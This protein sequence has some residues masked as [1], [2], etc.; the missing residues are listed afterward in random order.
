MTALA[1]ATKLNYL[2]DKDPVMAAYGLDGDLKWKEFKGVRVRS[3]I[4][5]YTGT[6]EE[7]AKKVR[8]IREA[9]PLPPNYNPVRCELPTCYCDLWSHDFTRTEDGKIVYD[10]ALFVFMSGNPTQ[11]PHTS[12]E[13][14]VMEV[15]REYLALPPKEDAH[16]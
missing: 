2:I 5:R 10:A 12:V 13:E 7:V 9:C 1:E 6:P 4:V 14:V 8:E 11:H 16:A 3:R 15:V